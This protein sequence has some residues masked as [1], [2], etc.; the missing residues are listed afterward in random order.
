[1]MP[2][3][4]C[5]YAPCAWNGPW[6]ACRWDGCLHLCC[7]CCGGICDPLVNDGES[8]AALDRAC[9]VGCG[10]ILLLM[11]GFTAF[12]RLGDAGTSDL[13]MTLLFLL[14]VLGWMG[15]ALVVYR[16]KSKP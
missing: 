9:V 16:K 15:W 14:G 4:Q 6:Y 2:A 11:I 7:P 3:W 1:M 8:A 10:V 12:D 5:R 13:R